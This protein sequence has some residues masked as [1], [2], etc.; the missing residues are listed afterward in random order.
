MPCH[1]MRNVHVLFEVGS[2]LLTPLKVCQNLTSYATQ[3]V[4]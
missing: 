2:A 3:T 4:T 1:I